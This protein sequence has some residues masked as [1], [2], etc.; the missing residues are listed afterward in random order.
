MSPKC[1]LPFENMC[2][3]LKFRVFSPRCLF[4]A[5]SASNFSHVWS[6]WSKLEALTNY[7]Q[8]SRWMV[9]QIL[10]HQRLNKINFFTSESSTPARISRDSC[11]FTSCS[12]LVN[13]TLRGRPQRKSLEICFLGNV[14]ARQKDCT[15]ETAKMGGKTNKPSTQKKHAKGISRTSNLMC[16]DFSE[17]WWIPEKCDG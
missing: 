1:P 4:Y 12:L 17:V 11:V 5:V 6:C 7:C 16:V 14:L 2:A 10:R 3:V 13:C 8:E 9:P 15:K